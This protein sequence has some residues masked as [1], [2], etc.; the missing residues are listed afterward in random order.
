MTTSFHLR[1]V[2]GNGY[3]RAILLYVNYPPYPLIPVIKL[4]LHLNI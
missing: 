4:A 1:R 2:Q 3:I